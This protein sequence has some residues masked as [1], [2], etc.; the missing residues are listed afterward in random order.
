MI[1][2]QGKYLTDEV[3]LKTR[4]E[5]NKVLPSFEAIIKQV[6]QQTTHPEELSL[7]SEPMTNFKEYNSTEM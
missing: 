6:P 4:I 1:K 3:A 5:D 7:P 2:L